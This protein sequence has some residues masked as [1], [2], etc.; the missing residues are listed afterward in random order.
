MEFD[1]GT[2][3]VLV[4]TALAVVGIFVLRH[5]SGSEDHK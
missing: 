3:V 2:I 4:L 1:A 5:L